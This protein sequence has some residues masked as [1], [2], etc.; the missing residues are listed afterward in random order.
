MMTTSTFTP[1]LYSTMKKD[2]TEGISRQKAK[3]LSSTVLNNRNDH[4]ENCLVQELCLTSLNVTNAIAEGFDQPGKTELIC[5]LREAKTLLSRFRSLTSVAQSCQLLDR[6]T[7]DQWI[8]SSVGISK[9][10]GG[11]MKKM[12]EQQN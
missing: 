4:Y 8:D 3:E 6:K 7:S 10:I 5:S 2:F 12:T 9:L 11:F 1:F